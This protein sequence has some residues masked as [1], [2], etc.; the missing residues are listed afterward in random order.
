MANKT[1][2]ERLLDDA[3]IKGGSPIDRVIGMLLERTEAV[4]ELHDKLG[5]ELRELRDTHTDIKNVMTRMADRQ[6]L[7]EK[8][9]HDS[10]NAVNNSNN[11]IN[12][13][14]DNLATQIATAT[15]ADAIQKAQFHTGWKVIVII[16]GIAMAIFGIFTV[17]FNHNWK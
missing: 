15:T 4:R 17:F 6:E 8:T 7:H 9:D 13:K 10:F 11:L 12:A 1:N 16:G 14:L 5:T 2:P 3:G